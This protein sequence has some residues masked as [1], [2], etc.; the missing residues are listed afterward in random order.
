M[1]KAIIQQQV[2][3]LREEVG[4]RLPL[5]GG[6]MSG[7]ITYTNQSSI[8][9]HK[10]DQHEYLEVTARSMRDGSPVRAGALNVFTRESPKHAG[11]FL[12]IAEG[13]SANSYLLGEPGK[14]LTWDGLIL[15]TI[16]SKQDKFIKFSS[17]RLIAYGIINIPS[18]TR[19]IQVSLPEPLD[20]TQYVVLPSLMSDDPRNVLSYKNKT[21]TGFEIVRI[22]SGDGSYNNAVTVNWA[23]IKL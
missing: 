20:N 3:D 16:E 1:A 2:D 6:E 21:T 22:Y 15:D 8:G 9:Y 19:S 17:G 23:V 10:D 14:D 7:S 5:S 4:N 13:D 12:L 18:G 11:G